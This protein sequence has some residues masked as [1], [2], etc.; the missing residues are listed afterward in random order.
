M[1][2]SFEDYQID[3]EQLFEA[4]AAYYAGIEEAKKHFKTSVDKE[5]KKMLKEQ[6][7]EDIKISSDDKIDQIFKPKE[8]IVTDENFEELLLKSVDQGIE[9]IKSEQELDEFPLPHHSKQKIQELKKKAKKKAK[10][11]VKSND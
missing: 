8:D 5:V 4:K 11:S 6:N 2:K 9:L 7:E 3:V 1:I 10:K